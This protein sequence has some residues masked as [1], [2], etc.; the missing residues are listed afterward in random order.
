[1]KE[2]KP[3][4]RRERFENPTLVEVQPLSWWVGKRKPTLNETN[5]PEGMT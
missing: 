2:M 5:C 3:I 4:V 1:M